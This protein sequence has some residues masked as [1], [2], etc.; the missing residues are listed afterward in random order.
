MSRP[1]DTPGKTGQ[2][3]ERDDKFQRRRR[4]GTKKN[5]ERR[6]PGSLLLLCFGQGSVTRSIR[7]CVLKERSIFG[8]RRAVLF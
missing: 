8:N 4:R 5:E 2:P 6:N 7:T 3:I 1:V